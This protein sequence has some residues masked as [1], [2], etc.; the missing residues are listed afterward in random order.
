[1]KNLFKKSIAILFLAIYAVNPLHTILHTCHD[2]GH[3]HH[4]KC[5]SEQ[6]KQNIKIEQNAL[7][8]NTIHDCSLC[9]NNIDKTHTLLSE[10]ND[11]SSIN[12]TCIYFLN[13]SDKKPVSKSLFFVDSRGPPSLV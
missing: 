6:N 7:N 10:A 3:K 1:M 8:I 4:G 13:L 5:S 11:N 9:Q 12:I 2:H